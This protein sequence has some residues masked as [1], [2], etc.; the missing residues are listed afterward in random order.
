MDAPDGLPATPFGQLT[1][2]SIS[3]HELFLSFVDA[4][5]SED[6]ATTMIGAILIGTT[7]GNA[8]RPGGE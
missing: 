8:L 7:I 6:Q 3:M 1:E 2:A 5:F 4:G